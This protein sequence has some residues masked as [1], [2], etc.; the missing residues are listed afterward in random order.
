MKG[1]QCMTFY[2]NFYG[3]TMSCVVVYVQRPDGTERVVWLKSGHWGD[4]WIKTQVET[5]DK[6]AEYRVGFC[7]KIS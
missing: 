2:Y 5:S 7:C 4:R 3:T 1:K 6:T